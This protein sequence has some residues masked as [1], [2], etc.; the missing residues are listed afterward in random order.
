[1][2]FETLEQTKARLENWRRAFKDHKHYRVTPSLEGKY[3]SPQC[4]E[5]REP[6]TLIDMIDAINVER[7]IIGM[8]ALYKA[9]LK[10]HYFTPFIP[11]QIFCRKN[12]I[13]L[14][15]YQLEEDKSVRM[16]SNRLRKN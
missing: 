13:R 16:I 7:A 1:M 3:R 2:D 9:I 6:N 14:D 11:L 15:Q 5:A 4:W 8:P 10:Y 12:R